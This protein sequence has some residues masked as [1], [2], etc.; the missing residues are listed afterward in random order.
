MEKIIKKSAYLCAREKILAYIQD[1]QLYGKRLPSETEFAQAMGISRNTVR[2]AIRLLEQERVVYSRHGVGTFVIN[3][4]SQL[5]SNIAVFHSIS[6]IIRSHGYRPGTRSVV[7]GVIQADG[8]LAAKLE[9][10]EGAAVLAVERV[11][12]ADG[13]PVILVRDYLPQLP[14]MEEKYAG[15]Q[16][17]SFLD[18]LKKNYEVEIGYANC[19]IRAMI[20][21]EDLG[22]K[23]QLQEP[24]ALIVL[25][26]FHYST[27]GRMIFYSD[28]YF[29]SDKFNFNVIRQSKR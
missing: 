27:D 25:S 18:F 4:G 10:G 2:E 26:Q 16:E 12:T 6:S 1:N 11:R 19:S 21:D 7:T 24:T 17:E 28:S 8:E 5:S 15:G 14:G 23:L 22:A 20:S 29:V 9:I 3:K 13:D